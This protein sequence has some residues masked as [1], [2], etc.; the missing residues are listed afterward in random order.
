MIDAEISPRYNLINP[1][2]KQDDK[3]MDIMTALKAI[4]DDTRMKIITLL[5]QHNYCVRALAG[6][7]GISEAGVSQHLKI[8]REAGL[9]SGEKKGY[10]VHYSVNRDAL[11]EI[12]GNIE[13]LACTEPSHEGGKCRCREI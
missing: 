7:L 6:K 8:L 3:I 1:I 13:S 9:V 11:R 4:S 5:L 2:L 12:A 10:F